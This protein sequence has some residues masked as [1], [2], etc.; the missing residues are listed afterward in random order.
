MKTLLILGA[1]IYQVPLI[2][3]ARGMGL[4]T[5]VASVDGDWPGFALADVVCKVDTTDREG[6]LSVAEREQIDGIVTAG[7]DVAVR[8]IGY[9]CD[10][11]GLHGI[12][13]EAAEKLTDKAKMKTAFR[14]IVKSGDFRIVY[15]AEEAAEAASAIGYPVMVKAVDVSGSRG[16][17]RVDD[18]AG[19]AAAV[20]EAYAVTRREYIVIEEVVRGTE[21]GLDAFVENG[22][23]AAFY[24]H[25]KYVWKSGGR[26]IPAG[27]GFPFYGDEELTGAL[28]AELEHIIAATGMDNCAVNCD[29]M[30]DG[31]EVSVIE[32]GGR[33]GATCI[34]EL[35]E[36]YSG[37]DYYRQMILCALGEPTDFTQQKADPCIARLLMSRKAG[38]VREIDRSLVRDLGAETGAAIQLDVKEGDPVRSA[39]NGTDRI[40]H[41]IM[42]STS[43]RQVEE[44]CGKVLEAVHL[45]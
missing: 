26:T 6:I 18:A 14:G 44:I 36:M 28:R 30:V 3:R 25:T 29:I 43:Y 24:P 23:I 27:H 32:A 8:S 2:R 35:I 1:G 17:T 19:L 10:T 45:G 16:I 34:P 11:L 4:R 40:G 21:I 5:V 15:S 38:T 41:V 12:S 37:V 39:A 42:R 31:G 22:R 33:S 20:S 13:A 9:V 7:T